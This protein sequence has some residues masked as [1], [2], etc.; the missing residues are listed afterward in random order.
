MIDTRDN[1]NVVV[2]KDTDVLIIFN[3][4]IKSMSNQSD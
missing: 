1:R 4:V 2:S 3:N